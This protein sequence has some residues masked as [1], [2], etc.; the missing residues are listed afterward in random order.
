MIKKDA[1]SKKQQ[2]TETRY[3]RQRKGCVTEGVKSQGVL[4]MWYE[5]QY[6]WIT[7]CTSQTMREIG[8]SLYLGNYAPHSH[9]GTQ[10]LGR[11]GALPPPLTSHQDLANQSTASPWPLIGSG[12]NKCLKR[13]CKW[14]LLELLKKNNSLRVTKATSGHLYHLTGR[15]CLKVRW[16]FLSC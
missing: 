4:G 15:I 7:R 16:I 8:W 12:L 10:S 1:A 6:S 5:V 9:C 2:E 13:H 3:F 14:Q 11:A